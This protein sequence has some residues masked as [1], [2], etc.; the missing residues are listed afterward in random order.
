MKNSPTYTIKFFIKV[1]YHLIGMFLK[2]HNRFNEF[3]VSKN[4]DNK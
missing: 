3:S 4:F 2:E 1:I